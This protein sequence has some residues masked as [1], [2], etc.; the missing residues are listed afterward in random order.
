MGREPERGNVGLELPTATVRGSTLTEGDSGLSRGC[1]PR[2]RD[3]VAH[4]AET[5]R[6]LAV[7]CALTALR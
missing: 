3:E 7:D 1:I 6:L 2:L 4:R 5:G